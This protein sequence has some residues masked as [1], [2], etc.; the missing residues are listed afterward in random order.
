MG[1]IPMPGGWSMSAMWLPVCGQSWLG[2]AAGFTRTWAWMMVPM[3][4]PLAVVPLLNYRATLDGRW[5]PLL[6]TAAAG[7]AWAATWTALGLPVYLAG[8]AVAQTLLDTP[9]LAR[10]V[11]VMAAV[12]GVAGAAWHLAAWRRR[13]VHRALPGPPVCAAALRHG[14]RLGGHCVR[15]CAGLT[16]ALLAA[17]IMERSTMVCAFVFVAAES[18]RLRER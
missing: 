8:A 18:V 16:V 17:G 13:P 15:R 4:L 12:A 5:H 3:M 7:L 11:P 1:Q 2:A 10:M 9:A 14:A 6:L